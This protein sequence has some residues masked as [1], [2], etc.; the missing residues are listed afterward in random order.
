MVGRLICQYIS[1]IIH[2]FDF[3]YIFEN[4]KLAYSSIMINIDVFAANNIL[5]YGRPYHVY[6]KI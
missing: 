3:C 6:V 4:Q 1:Q 5:W 2:A